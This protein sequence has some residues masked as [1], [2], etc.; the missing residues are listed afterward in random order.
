MQLRTHQTTQKVR[1][2]ASSQAGF[3]LTEL[4]AGILIF[5]LLTGLGALALRSFW[6]TQSLERAKAEVVT[7]MRQAQQ[8]AMSE[9]HPLV[10][11]VWFEPDRSNW[12]VV[13]Y[14]PT[15][16]SDKCSKLEEFKFDG[17]VIIRTPNF[18]GES[19]IRA[20][21]DAI[22]PGTGAPQRYAFFYPRGGAT[23]GTVMLESFE[24]DDSYL[25]E[26]KGVTGRVVAP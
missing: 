12:G 1:R 13:K 21:C 11:G 6:F 24:G 23:P 15:A 20:E 10:Y 2:L 19:V 26:V 17:G 25:V 7:Q 5:G 14:D 4:L 3:T 22:I 18:T 16:T 8:R 9:S